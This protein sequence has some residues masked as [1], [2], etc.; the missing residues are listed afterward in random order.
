MILA[1]LLDTLLPAPHE[2]ET[3]G[4]EKSKDTVSPPQG[5]LCK[6]LKDEVGPGIEHEQLSH[7][8]RLVC[9]QAQRTS[10]FTSCP[11]CRTWWV[12]RTLS[13]V[14][15]HNLAAQFCIRSDIFYPCVRGTLC[16]PNA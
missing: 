7:M 5:Q 10:S 1:V 11:W 3:G 12:R 4:F 14:I 16:M 6:W 8:V 9:C 15:S 13:K 2:G